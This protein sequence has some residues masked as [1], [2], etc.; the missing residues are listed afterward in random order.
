MSDKDLLGL[1]IGIG[2][3]AAMA[4]YVAYIY[5]HPQRFGWLVLSPTDPKA[6]PIAVKSDH[7]RAALDPPGVVP[8]HSIEDKF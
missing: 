7:H 4:A 3:L 2:L 5:F 6:P 8:I 1:L